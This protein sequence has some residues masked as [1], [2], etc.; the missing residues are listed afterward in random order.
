MNNQDE[1]AMKMDVICRAV[2][3]TCVDKASFV[4]F[5]K[6]FIHDIAVKYPYYFI[7]NIVYV[8]TLYIYI[9]MF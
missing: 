8:S 9:H 7:K 4:G 2:F 1:L 5:E 3:K 6:K